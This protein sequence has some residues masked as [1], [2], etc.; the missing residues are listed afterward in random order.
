[1]AS[2]AVGDKLH[3]KYGD[4]EFYPAEVVAV[5]GKKARKQAPIKV[6]YVGYEEQAWLPLADLKSKKI[7]KELS[8]ANAKG[9]AKAKA[10]GK[11]AAKAGNQSS[12][13]TALPA[14]TRLQAELDGVWYSAEV[15]QVSTS[16]QRKKAPVKVH[17]AGWDAKD[18]SWMPLEKL[19]SKWLTKAGAAAPA[20]KKSDGPD[21]SALVKGTKVQADF[22]GANYKA[23]VVQVSQSASRKKAP[24]KVH[25]VGYADSDDRWLPVTSVKSKLLKGGAAKEAAGPTNASVV[26]SLEVGMRLQAEHPADKTYY[27]ATIV[28]IRA[29]G[30]VKVNFVGWGAED[31]LWLPLDKLKS[32]K[33]PKDLGKATEKATKQPAGGLVKGTRLQAEGPDGIMYAAEVVTVSTA[34]AR[35]KAPVKVH[36]M[37]HEDVYDLWLPYSKLQS[38][39]VKAGAPAKA[40][41]KQAPAKPA[42][43]AATPPK[44]G[45]WDFSA[46]EKGMK[47]QAQGP[48]GIWYG[49][50]V[51]A[52]SPKKAKPVKVNFVGYGSE[53]D[54]W[55]GGESL[56]SKYIKQVKPQAALPAPAASGGKGKGGKGQKSSKGGKSQAS[57]KGSGKGGKEGKS[58]GGKGKR[59]Y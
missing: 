16:S 51:V 53:F 37:G 36:F 55:L 41:P 33:I 49:A 17:W 3:A 30:T 43:A 52:I 25:Y 22:D 9:K 14:G 28:N 50:T 40:A 35:A 15:A 26:K 29:K 44:V 23:E 48:D 38:K 6:S 34:K 24:I 8:T 21:L 39:H 54:L 57:G 18:D 7:P 1:M 19:R 45:S 31:D 13:S 20:A 59:G 32:K 11:A 46:C 27:A 2:L 10:K 47:L 12:L 4:G 5:A 58:K 56:Q 42:K